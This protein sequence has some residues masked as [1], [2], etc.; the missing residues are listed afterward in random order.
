[1]ALHDLYPS[2]PRFGVKRTNHQS[3]RSG[4]AS[5]QASAAPGKDNKDNRPVVD[6]IFA[7]P[8]EH[9]HTIKKSLVGRW[10]HL[11]HERIHLPAGWMWCAMWLVEAAPKLKLRPS[12][13]DVSPGLGMRVELPRR[14]API[15]GGLVAVFRLMGIYGEFDQSSVKD[16]T[17]RKRLTCDAPKACRCFSCV[18]KHIIT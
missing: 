3:P 5:K 13:R 2:H 4:S 7:R 14:H 18:R 10:H 8:N 15:L 17:P 12:V 11:V 16:G 1:M 6:R 9:V